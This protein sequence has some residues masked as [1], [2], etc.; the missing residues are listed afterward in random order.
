MVCR[1]YLFAEKDMKPMKG[2]DLIIHTHV[3]S[4]AFADIQVD[5]MSVR[6][7]K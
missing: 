3:S 4:D 5:Y 1:R 7:R 6:N 2:T